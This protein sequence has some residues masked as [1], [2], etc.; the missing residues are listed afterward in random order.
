MG[1]MNFAKRIALFLL[2]NFLVITTISI[3]MNVLGVRPY[4]TAYG[5][6]Y[7]S[8][9]FFCAIW[10]IGGA[11]ISLLMSRQIAKWSLNVETIRPDTRNPDERALYEM[12]EELAKRAHLSACPEVGIYRSKEVN[13]FATGPSAKRGLVAVSTGLL[14]QLNKEQ[15][16]GVLG[17]EIGHIANGD[18]VT[19]TLLQGV[20]NAFVMFLARI[21]A[22]V[23]SGVGRNRENQSLA[24][25]FLFLYVF[26]FTFMLLGSMIIAFY[27]RFREFRADAAG[28]RLASK[29]SMIS[30]LKALQTSQEV[31]D[32]R[33]EKPA[34]AAFKISQPK[35][36]GLLLSLFASHPPLPERIARLE[37]TV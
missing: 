25:Y 22:S 5:L 28:A 8:L 35:K 9:L 2:V 16:R 12:V 10:G 31:R 6:D 30:A 23:F 3:V 26:E 17:H 34:L 37:K 29:S 14:E 24:S 1:P 33:S 21:L 15:L 13:A 4:L 11:L 27:S 36:V 7:Q 32:P 20:V 18:M 19:M